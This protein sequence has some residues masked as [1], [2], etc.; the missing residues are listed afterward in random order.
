MTPE[1]PLRGFLI[2][3]AMWTNLRQIAAP[4]DDVV[5]LA[6]AKAQLRIYASDDDTYLRRLIRA[7]TATVEGPNGIGRALL[8]QTWVAT[9]DGFPRGSLKLPLG[10]VIEC[11]SISY[12]D[13][14]DGDITAFESFS[15]DDHLPIP[16]VSPV[17]SWPIAGNHP[18]SVRVVFKCGY[19]DYS[20][21]VPADLIQAILM[22]VAHWFENRE[23]VSDR[24]MKDV[25]MGVE[26]ILARYRVHAFA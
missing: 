23:A 19:G 17:G 5:I 9:F 15:L 6:E 1:P 4:Q 24:P 26:S 8:T 14:P 25:P 10:P 2:N 18:G 11:A 7:A 16:A 12:E 3:I 20:E 22:L 21:D 13:V